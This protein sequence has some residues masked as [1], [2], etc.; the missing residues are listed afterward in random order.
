MI[1]VIYYRLKILIYDKMS[2]FTFA[3]IFLAMLA[4]S[5]ITANSVVKQQLVPISIIDLDNS[6]YSAL[7][8]DRLSKQPGIALHPSNLEDAERKVSS[9]KLEAAYMIR[10]GFMDSIIDGDISGIIEIIKSPSSLTSDLIGEIVSSEVIRLS[11]NVASADMVIDEFKD[12]GREID[13]PKESQ[14]WQEVWKSTDALWEPKPLM[15]IDYKEI[16]SGQ[17]AGAN[18][19]AG[20][21]A[22]VSR[23]AITATFGFL[24]TFLMYSM[25]MAGSWLLDEKNNGILHR[26]VSHPMKL[27]TYI[28]GNM[29][30]AVIL[31]YIMAALVIALI[32]A[33][34]K[35]EGIHVIEDGLMLMAYLICTGFLS[36]FLASAMKTS[37]QLHITVP[38]ITL[39]TGFLGGNFVPLGELSNVFN[40]FGA[41]TPQYWFSQGIMNTYTTGSVASLLWPIT[42]LSLLSI[43][44]LTGTHIMMKVFF[45]KG[46][47]GKPM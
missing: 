41:L 15:T 39:A 24:S 47:M 16:S 29:F 18:T 31:N 45:H 2:W 22:S 19:G 36:L 9:G 34:F 26:V 43:L 23:G 28:T 13:N 17:A 27:M 25:L 20:D 8:V 12:M 30:S 11:S 46:S 38:V 40:W 33:V 44:L 1:N 35:L 42:V 4:V 32:T 10:E 14:L 7:V 3:G 37:M 21:S 6:E 5:W